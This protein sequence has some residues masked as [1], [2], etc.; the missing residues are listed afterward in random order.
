M[1]TRTSMWVQSF[2][3]IG[4]F[5]PGLYAGWGM[6]NILRAMRSSSRESKR[7]FFMSE[8]G[9]IIPTRRGT[10]VGRRGGRTTGNNDIPTHRGCRS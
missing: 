10:V 4:P 7:I 2:A 1:G 6:G 3:N 5:Y 9:L 8:E